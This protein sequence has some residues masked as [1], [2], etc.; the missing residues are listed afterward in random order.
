[1]AKKSIS[2][3]EKF[4]AWVAIAALS[5]GLFFAFSVPVVYADEAFDTDMDGIPNF[6]EWQ[7]GTN[8]LDPADARAWHPYDMPPFPRLVANQG[9]WDFAWQQVLF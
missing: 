2:I 4:F 5:V 6:E 9:R 3:R 8:P 1:M 7:D